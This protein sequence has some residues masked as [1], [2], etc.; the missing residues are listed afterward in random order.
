MSPQAHSFFPH[1]ENPRIYCY[2]AYLILL[3]TNLASL[4]HKSHFYVSTQLNY[5]LI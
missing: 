1:S 4:Q 5:A 3:F 2:S